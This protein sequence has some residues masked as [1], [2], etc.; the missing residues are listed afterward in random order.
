MPSDDDNDDGDRLIEEYDEKTEFPLVLD[1]ADRL[2]GSLTPEVLA[3]LTEKM[4]AH[5]DGVA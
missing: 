3:E 1:L 4:G 2:D 5:N